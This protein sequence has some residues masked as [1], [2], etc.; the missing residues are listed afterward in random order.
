[1]LCSSNSHWTF[2]A[3]SKM[4]TEKYGRRTKSALLLYKKSQRRKLWNAVVEGIKFYLC[5]NKKEKKE[6]QWCIT[7]FSCSFHI[8]WASYQNGFLIGWPVSIMLFE[9]RSFNVHFNISCMINHIIQVFNSSESL[10][11]LKCIF[12]QTNVNVVLTLFSRIIFPL[13]F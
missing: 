4:E 8:L 3:W 2:F 6:Q 9:N 7:A 5:L 11:V 1:M 10:C 12:L 13:L